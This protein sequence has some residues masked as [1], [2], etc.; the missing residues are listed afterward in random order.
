MSLIVLLY[1]IAAGTL[2]W[3]NF[4]WIL[5]SHCCTLASSVMTMASSG[6]CKN[7]LKLL[8]CFVCSDHV[9]VRCHHSV[10]QQ[11]VFSVFCANYIEL[12]T[13]GNTSV[14]CIW[15]IHFI[16]VFILFPVFL[17]S[18]FFW[19]FWR[20]KL[21]FFLSFFVSLQYLRL[22][23]RRPWGRWNSITDWR[24]DSGEE[25]CRWRCCLSSVY[26]VCTECVPTSE[27]NFSAAP[28]LTLMLVFLQ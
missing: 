20:K 15:F 19:V 9:A 10:S 11:T 5:W 6:F 13:L 25:T 8:F 22:F 17:V 27:T 24:F 3:W 23:N 1:V 18:C 4:I 26:R 16:C 21:A 7:I 12:I 2:N 28:L 14:R